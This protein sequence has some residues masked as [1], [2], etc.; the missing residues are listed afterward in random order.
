MEQKL[1][2]VFS[3]SAR[4]QA[5]DIDDL[6]RIVRETKDAELQ[7]ENLPDPDYPILFVSATPRAAETILA[8]VKGW[9]CSR[10]RALDR[11]PG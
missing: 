10:N 8:S 5:T 9:R 4:G 7:R 2:Y 3:T 1:N 11:F 6:R